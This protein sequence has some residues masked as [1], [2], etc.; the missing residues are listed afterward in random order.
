M[1]GTKNDQAH[2]VN[3]MRE[4]LLNIALKEEGII[5]SLSDYLDKT[6][7]N[8]YAHNK[9]LQKEAMLENVVMEKP[10]DTSAQ[11]KITQGLNQIHEALSQKNTDIQEIKQ[12]L[13]FIFGIETVGL[14]SLESL[15]QKLD[16]LNK[17]NAALRKILSE[18][19]TLP[20]KIGRIP[21]QVTAEHLKQQI[22]TLQKKLDTL[23]KKNMNLIAKQEDKKT[24]EQKDEKTHRPKAK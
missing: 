7:S 8:L 23:Y 10:I 20:I 15:N 19:K 6:L 18:L 17:R 9:E 13:N 1:V 5:K 11:Q 12:K 3:E 2:E 21:A 24:L 22:Q 14:E 16:D 4:A